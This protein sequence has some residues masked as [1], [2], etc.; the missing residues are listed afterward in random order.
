MASDVGAGLGA[1]PHAIDG[2]APL[3]PVEARGLTK[4][5]GDVV[6][7][8]GVTFD[9]RRGEVVGILGPNGAGKTTILRMLAGILTP[10]AGRASIVGHDVVEEAFEVKRRIGFL[11]GDTNLY[12]RLTPREILRFFG[13][14]HEMSRAAIAERTE[15]LATELRMT[16]VLDR[17]CGALST[18]QTQKAN[19]ARAFLHDPPVLVLDEPTSSLDVITGR[20]VLDAIRRARGAGK[21]VLFSTH[22]MSEA[23]HVCDRILLLHSGRILDAGTVA[24]LCARAGTANLTEAFLRLVDRTE[25]TAR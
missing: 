19:L 24:E 13:E 2:V 9:V 20:F 10:S 4:R 5:Y 14:L 23:E 1:P 7:A 8:D 17:R 15:R 3:H 12:E 6:A 22:V 25:A 11:S 21:A 18:G 16:D